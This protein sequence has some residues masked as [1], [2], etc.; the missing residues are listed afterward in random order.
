MNYAVVSM[1]CIDRSSKT[2]LKNENFPVNSLLL[3]NF[4]RE[5]CSQM[6]SYTTNQSPLE[7]TVS[8]HLN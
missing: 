5:T 6:T 3:G 1:A 7:L 4:T 8:P 2:D